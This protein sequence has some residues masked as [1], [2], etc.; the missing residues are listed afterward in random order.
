MET[1]DPSVCPL[2][3]AANQCAMEIAKATGRP[4]ERCWCVDSMFTPELLATV[5]QA[6]QG[7]SCICAGCAASHRP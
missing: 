4:V 2:C 7:L 5:P 6:T 3:G 1:I